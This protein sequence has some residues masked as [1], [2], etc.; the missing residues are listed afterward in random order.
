MVILS[1]SLQENKVKLSSKRIC[2]VVA[3][4]QNKMNTLLT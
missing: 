4:Q 1:E 2:G 3:L